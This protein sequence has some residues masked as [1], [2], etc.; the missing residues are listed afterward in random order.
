MDSA[1]RVLVERGERELPFIAEVR[2][3]F[4][5]RM[6]VVPWSPVEPVGPERLRELAT[7]S[8]RIPIFEPVRG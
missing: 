1:I 7:G 6:T 4:S 8:G 3:R 5:R 2:E